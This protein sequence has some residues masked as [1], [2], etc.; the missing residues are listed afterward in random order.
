M[1]EIE[2]TLNDRPLTFGFSELGNPEPLTLAHLLYGCRITCL[3]YQ[4]VE[5]D[6]L[7]DSSYREAG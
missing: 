4:S 5:V 3:P 1:V 6:E 2:A 7:T